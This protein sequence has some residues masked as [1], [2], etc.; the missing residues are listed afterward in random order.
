[1]GIGVNFN[2]FDLVGWSVQDFEKLQNEMLALM[3]SNQEFAKSLADLV[4]LTE[5][6]EA[7]RQAVFSEQ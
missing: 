3:A 7:H 4:D 6:F 5:N 1:M 2:Q